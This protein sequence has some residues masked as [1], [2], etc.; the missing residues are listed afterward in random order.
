MN[1]HIILLFVVLLFVALSFFVASSSIAMEEDTVQDVPSMSSRPLES[2]TIYGTA[3]KDAYGQAGFPITPT[4]NQ[5]N[6][7]LGY[8]AIYSKHQTRIYVQ[9]DL[10]IPAGVKIISA[11]VQLYQYV[12]RSATAYGVTAYSVDC[13]WVEFAVSWNN[14]PCKGAAIANA[15]FSNRLGWQTI[16][17]TDLARQWHS[18]SKINYGITIWAKNE[19]ARGGIF[20]SRECGGSQCP[21]QEHPRIKIEYEE[22]PFSCTNIAGIPTTECQTLET[23]YN[24]LGGDSWSTKTGWL[25]TNSP[26]S[27]SG[28]TCNDGHV[29]ALNLSN[30][31]LI[32]SLPTELGNLIN[33]TSLFLN[34]NSLSAP[35]PTSLTTL[36]LGT[37]DFSNTDLCVPNAEKFG[38]WL[39]S[40]SDLNPAYE[41]VP[42]CDSSLGITKTASTNR[43]QPGD[44]VDY[45]IV[46]AVQ[47]STPITLTDVLSSTG[48]SYVKDSLS[49]SDS[50][51]DCQVNEGILNCRGNLASEATVRYQLKADT[52]LAP[53]SI[54][55]QQA[56]VDRPGFW[57]SD[58]AAIVV[59]DPEFRETLV[60]I[61]ASLDNNLWQY[62]PE[63]LNRAE[64]AA[65]NEFA[66][67]LVVLDGPSQGDAYLYRLEEDDTPR[68]PSFITNNPTCN[69]KYETGQTIWEWSEYLG[70]PD[71]LVEFLLA[72]QWAYPNAQNVDQV[73]LILTG[74]GNGLSHDLYTLAQPADR[75]GKPADR[76]G[77]PTSGA[78]QPSGFLLD[79]TPVR[80]A[81]SVQ[82]LGVALREFHKITGDT[83]GLLYLDACMM[84]MTE[85]AYEVRDSVGYLL[86]SQNWAWALFPYDAHLNSINGRLNPR[87]IGEAWLA[88][89]AAV[90]ESGEF[91]YTLSL[92]DVSQIEDVADALNTLGEDLTQRMAINAYGPDKVQQARLAAD[93]FDS[94][95]DGYINHEDNY[96]DVV[97]F[98]RQI[99][100]KFS[101]SERTVAAAEL[102]IQAVEA[103]V[104]KE[105]HK[106]GVPYYYNKD[107]W[108][109]GTLGGLSIYIPVLADEWE[110]RYYHPDHFAF[111]KKTQWDEFLAAYWTR[112][113]D[114][115]KPPPEP[116]CRDEECK[117]P[118]GPIIQP[119]IEL[120]LRQEGSDLVLRWL[121]QPTQT[122]KILEAIII[123]TTTPL[124][125]AEWRTIGDNIQNGRFTRLSKE[126][127]EG[128][129]YCYQV[130]PTEGGQPSNITCFDY[131]QLNLKVP[132]QQAPP[133]TTVF[134]PINLSNADGFCFAA[135]DITLTYNPKI[136]QPTGKVQPT[137]FTRN[138]Q[139]QAN[140][141]QPGR[142]RIS[143]MHNY[144]EP[145]Y[146]SGQLF[147][148]EF[149]I[150]GTINEYTPLDFAVGIGDT[151][152]YDIGDLLTPVPLNLWDGSLTVNSTCVLGDISCNGAIGSNDA[153]L[154]LRISVDLHTPTPE[155]QNACD[156][157][158]DGDCTS[159]DSSVILCLANEKNLADCR[160]GDDKE[161]LIVTRQSEQPILIELSKL[162]I[163]KIGDTIE[164][165]VRLNQAPEMAGGDFIFI[166]DSSKMT[167]LEV[168]L[169][170]A[171]HLFQ[172]AINLQN[173]GQIRFS[174][175]NDESI[176]VDSELFVI[177]FRVKKAITPVN[178]NQ[179]R[180]SDANGQDLVTNLRREIVIRQYSLSTNE[181]FLPVIIK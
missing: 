149:V 71:S 178:L 163:A 43:I 86:A 147:L 22:L 150:I 10:P 129:T 118:P 38:A 81:L 153:L 21:G 3:F 20:R 109:W 101:T 64:Q 78:M 48:L 58:G 100:D 73:A 136:L 61:Y 107:H 14:Q 63:F 154:A 127:T 84:A 28:V 166:Y 92:V 148:I 131:G 56:R 12:A 160:A 65:G 5:Q 137:A 164:L 173:P 103:A 2:K 120:T 105:A 94:T 13:N 67:T 4:G 111:T 97:S 162:P 161:R 31:G 70:T 165:W 11:E 90:L 6:F 17:I 119:K 47:S 15:N 133:K 124:T 145:L 30:N 50:E 155:Q 170:D 99:Q 18:G 175:A 1:K 177:T 37:F 126:L 88:N 74:H 32:G 123:N 85:V 80:S 93:C 66:R 168:E 83:I 44:T 169:A 179:V 130:Q 45:E 104:I 117:L 25:Q 79:E 33:L 110:R 98:A 69:G 159:A 54:L 76:G 181:V 176:G 87:E 122:F 171:P 146:G 7:Y 134:V 140:T 116:A 52:N 24:T 144:C 113:N 91:P 23:L 128:Q 40:I 57:K 172:Q 77:K 42:W 142:V 68:C 51:I 29:T 75:G 112:N 135:G 141:S 39:P 174:L 16:N 26:C 27:W 89:E 102:V 167:A 36:N 49:V 139:F 158:G 121:S 46:L 156:V 108:Q 41:A 72:A 132:H 180:L 138:Y 82:D 55:Y 62:G 34:D 96:C 8:D 53:G 143:T 95:L 106:N 151:E 60:L 114:N 35:L 9:F 59:P 125:Q 152:L 19:N 115:H 157:T